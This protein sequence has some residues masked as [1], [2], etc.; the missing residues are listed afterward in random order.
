MFPETDVENNRDQTQGNRTRIKKGKMTEL[1]YRL[2]RGRYGGRTN[3]P[4]QESYALSFYY[5]MLSM[6]TEQAQ[7]PSLPIWFP[8]I[9]WTQAIVARSW[10][11]ER[12]LD[13]LE[14][15][16]RWVDSMAAAIP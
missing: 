10:G 6:W 11:R 13:T 16:G 14:D 9:G 2:E 4:T 7:S 1:N 8:S 12:F 15:C 3:S 5:Y